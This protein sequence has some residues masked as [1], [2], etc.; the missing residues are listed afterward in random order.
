MI[1]IFRLLLSQ[2]LMKSAKVTMKVQ[3]PPVHF[4]RLLNL[5]FASL[6]F[7]KDGACYSLDMIQ[8]N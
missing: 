4:E 6:P 2:N 1:R 8:A 7:R 5:K 3:F